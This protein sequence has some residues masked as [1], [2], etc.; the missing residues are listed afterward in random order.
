MNKLRLIVCV[1][2]GLT[3]AAILP[4]TILAQTQNKLSSPTPVDVSVESD[5]IAEETLEES[6][7]SGE[8][9][10]LQKIKKEDVTRPEET[11]KK[12]EI[13]DLFENRPISG[14]TPINFIGFTV[15]YAVGVGIP[16][17]TIILILLLPFLATL[18]AFV[19]HII[20]LPSLDILVPIAL[21]IA[22][23]ST[24]I[25][26]GSILLITILLAS[27]I[28]RFALRKVRIMQLP[29]KAL[30]I[31]IISVFV[32]LSLIIS[33]ANGIII[34]KQLSI[35]PILILILLGEQ[36]VSV[37]LTRSF[38]ETLTI[39]GV[40]IAMGLFG[41]FI[42]TTAM[43]RQA[44]LIYPEIILILLPINFMIGRYFG[45]RFTEFYRF[46]H[47]KSYGYK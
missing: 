31:L 15:Q 40:T 28:G 34:V 38:K 21:S 36:I 27:T 22:I 16:A 30:S 43:F 37:Q 23:V 4:T 41:F 7:A 5:S 11:E 1:F 19:R 18:I 25:V 10:K 45:L 6:T 29:K 14:L 13:L 17:N 35:F 46:S 42:L 12:G 47:I 44:I 2:L 24:G 9:E 32:F 8:E 20:G 26:A 3:L 33:A 39:T